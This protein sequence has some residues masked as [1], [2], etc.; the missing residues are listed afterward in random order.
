MYMYN[1]IN[2][3]SIVR[4]SYEKILTNR[5]ELNEKKKLI[6]KQTKNNFIKQNIWRII[7]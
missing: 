6:V 3:K 2:Y 1:Y 7:L 4:E 5:T